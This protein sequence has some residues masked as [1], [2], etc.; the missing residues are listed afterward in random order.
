V[1]FDCLNFRCDDYQQIRQSQIDGS[2][3]D[4]PGSGQ[5]KGNGRSDRERDTSIR[6]SSGKDSESF[7]QEM[8]AVSGNAD[9]GLEGS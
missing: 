7:E 1:Q 3:R 2:K 4:A 9:L 6:P 5:T 8:L